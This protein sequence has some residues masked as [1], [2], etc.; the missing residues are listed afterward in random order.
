MLSARTTAPNRVT[1]PSSVGWPPRSRT[2]R[3]PSQASVRSRT[4][5]YAAASTARR[6]RRVVEVE[7]SIRTSTSSP[8]ARVAG[9]VDGRV[10]ARP[11]ALERRVGAARALDQD[12]LDGADAR[13]VPLGR[14]PLHDLD[15]ALQPLVLDLVRHLVRQ[16]GSLGAVAR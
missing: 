1:E 14:D 9:E 3:Q 15:E 7:P 5:D 4:P 2:F 10:A 8:G 11:A 13:G 6:P 16:R 12:L